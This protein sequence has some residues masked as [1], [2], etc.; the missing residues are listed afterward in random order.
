M[1]LAKDGPIDCLQQLC[2]KGVEF[3]TDRFIRA[4]A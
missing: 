4:P 3:L 1:T 2:V